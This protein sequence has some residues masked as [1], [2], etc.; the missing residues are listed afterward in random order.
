MLTV[1]P[2][3]NQRNPRRRSAPAHMGAQNDHASTMAD[4]HPF[5]EAGAAAV[6]QVLSGDAAQFLKERQ[7]ESCE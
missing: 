7:Q 1:E 6:A 5:L 4:I 3:I 2:T